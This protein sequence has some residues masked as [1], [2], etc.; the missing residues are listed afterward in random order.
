[1]FDEKLI[2]NKEPSWPKISIVTPSYNQGE[3]IEDTILS[4]KNQDYPNIEHIIVDGGSSDNTL[5]ILKKY[6]RTYNMRWISE[7]DEGQAD[8]VNKGFAL[9]KGEIIGWLN[10]DDVYVFPF[11]ITNI[12]DQFSLRKVDILYGDML[13]IDGDNK[14]KHVVIKRAFARSL[15]L[16]LRLNLPQPST[17]FRKRVFEKHKLMKSLHWS[18]DYEYW[19]R[20]SAD[21]RVEYFPMILSAFRIHP[22]S[23]TS[24]QPEKF[25]EEIKQLS[26]I[27]NITLKHR[28]WWR[29]FDILRLF[30]YRAGRTWLSIM[31]LERQETAIPIKID[32][33]SVIRS[34]IS[35]GASLFKTVSWNRFRR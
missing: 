6:E 35:D 10:S 26:E 29:V 21:F 13:H 24:V 1:M 16:T 15:L 20:V 23:K 27:Y 28:Y 8:A 18:F 22:M 12:V 34:T 17:F 11:T 33:F 14:V 4:V 31:F 30:P 7:P 32:W 2:L 9:A 3:F 19:V 25:L 5:E